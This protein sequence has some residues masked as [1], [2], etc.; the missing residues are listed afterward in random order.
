MS[1]AQS[2]P[3]ARLSKRRPRGC[4]RSCRVASSTAAAGTD[5][6]DTVVSP[7]AASAVHVGANSSVTVIVCEWLACVAAGVHGRRPGAHERLSAWAVLCTEDF[8]CK[9]HLRGARRNRPRPVSSATAGMSKQGTVTS[10][11]RGSTNSGCRGV[12]L[13]RCPGRSSPYVSFPQLSVAVAVNVRVNGEGASARHR[14]CRGPP[15]SELNRWAACR[16]S[17]LRP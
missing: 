5:S 11:G 7:A 3:V 10:S 12:L 4:R 17:C 6:Q 2:P 1:C 8:L 14:S 15:K 13:R 9:P 16:R